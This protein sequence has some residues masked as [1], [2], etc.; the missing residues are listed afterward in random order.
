MTNRHFR[1]SGIHQWNRGFTIVEVLVTAGILAVL[2]AALVANLR[3]SW[4]NERVL[5]V[6]NEFASWINQVGSNTMRGRLAPDAANPGTF[7][8]PNGCTVTISIA[9]G[10]T[11]NINSGG[12]LATVTPNDDRCVPVG[13]INTFLIP[14]MPAGRFTVG[15]ITANTN[16]SVDLP[17]TFTL[18]GATTNDDPIEITFAAQG[19]PSTRC[20]QI[21]PILGQ[22][23]TGVMVGNACMID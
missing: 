8:N 18:R 6:A 10:A 14:Q 19:Q 17:F 4:E 21:S 16:P 9:A 23:R 22:V 5:A 7:L 3:R 11:S 1:L 20:V 12:L 2:M 15:N 13:Q